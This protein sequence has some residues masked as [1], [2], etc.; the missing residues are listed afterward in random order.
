MFICLYFLLP[1]SRQSHQLYGTGKSH[2]VFRISSPWT[3]TWGRGAASPLLA[4][5]LHVP[6][7]YFWKPAHHSD[8]H[9]WLPPPHTHVLLPLQS[10]FFRHLFHLYHHPKDAAEPLHPE[11]RHHLWRLPHSAVFFYPFCRTGHF[12]PFCNGLWPIRSYLPSTALHNQDEPPALC[13]AIAGILDI[14]CPGL[15]ATWFAGVAAVLLHW[16]GDP[17]FLL[18]NQS[19]YSTCL[20]WQSSQYHRDVF[21]HCAH[22][23]Y[24]PLWHCCFLFS[25]CLL[26][27]KDYISKREVQGIFH[28]WVSSFSCLLILWHRS[29]GVPQLCHYPKLQN[30]CNSLCDVHCGHANAESIYL[31][32]KEQG[33][34]RGSK[35]SCQHCHFQWVTGVFSLGLEKFS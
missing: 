29:W 7:N 13:L 21:C 23:H 12:P 9:L 17:P 30:Q 33:H 18:W 27:T 22:G 32:S 4:F 31:L 19:G 34:K 10:V 3:V 11:Q 14:E 35:K 20:F 26:H 5:P 15:F 6:D 28:L 16:L 8:H 24:S 2:T 25:D 1:L